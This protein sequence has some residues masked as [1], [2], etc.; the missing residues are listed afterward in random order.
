M[1]LHK[2]LYFFNNQ[3]LVTYTSSIIIHNI[4]HFEVKKRE[5]VRFSCLKSPPE[6]KAAQSAQIFKCTQCNIVINEL[7]YIT[8]N[9]IDVMDEESLT[10]SVFDL[11]KC[12]VLC[13]DGGA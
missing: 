12:T 2:T 8:Q 9:I 13:T 7:L 4:Y 11:G 5:L 3:L 10:R 6:I 1:F